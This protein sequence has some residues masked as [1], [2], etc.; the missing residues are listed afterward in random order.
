MYHGFIPSSA[1]RPRTAFSIPLL[2]F[3]HHM[4]LTSAIS[5]TGFIKGLANFLDSRQKQ[6]LLARGSHKRRQLRIPFTHS[7]DLYSRILMLKDQAFQAG[8]ELTAT[9][10]WAAKCPRCFGPQQNEVKSDP[11][12]PDFIIAM[13][14]NYQQRHYAYASKDSPSD[15]QYPSYF[16]APGDISPYASA[17]E[18][19][20][21][22]VV[23]IDV[24]K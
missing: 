9:Q 19:T 7:A 3:H 17:V 1:K 16:L 8:L 10:K 5:T 24:S 21:A 23:G 14:G 15:N 6:P 11:N 18:T 4:W 13:D 20:E 22:R 2:Q 12:E